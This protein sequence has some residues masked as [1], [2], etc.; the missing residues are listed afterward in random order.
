MIKQIQC[1]RVNQIGRQNIKVRIIKAPLVDTTI[2]RSVI[3]ERA[4]AVVI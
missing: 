2:L 3:S 1:K 4:R